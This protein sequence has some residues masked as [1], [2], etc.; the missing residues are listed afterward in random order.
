MK[1]TADENI[2]LVRE[3]FAGLGE[4]CCKPGRDITAADLQNTELLLVRSVTQVNEALLV[5]SPVKFVAS[6]TAGFDH[7]DMAYLQ[8]QGIGFARAPGSNALSAAEYVIAA[9][10]YWSIQSGRSLQSLTLGIIG[11]GQVGSRVAKLAAALG[12]V[13]VKNDPPLQ[14]KGGE[15]Y[16]SMAAALACDIVTLHVP[17]EYTGRHPTIELIDELAI[18]KL[19][20]N[21]VFINASRGEVLQESA[22][23][24][25]MHCRSDLTAILDV[26]HN[27]PQISTNLMAMAFLATPHIAGYSFDGKIRGTTMIYQ[28]CATFFELDPSWSAELPPS[29]LSLSDEPLNMSK[30]PQSILHAYDIK[31]DD[32]RLRKIASLKAE[33]QAAYFDQ[34]RKSYPVRREYSSLLFPGVVEL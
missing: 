1:I 19:K 10:C 22:L 31:A 11:C 23:L 24:Q 20:P 25:R 21:A 14:E 9:L 29:E 15:G 12:M 26:W 8:N 27:E 2:P 13:C 7:I 30:L 4:V 3:A 5:N 32:E 34:L 28:A 33:S 6:A 17:L 16:Q 18:D